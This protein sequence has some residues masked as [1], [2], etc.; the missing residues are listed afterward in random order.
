MGLKFS[1]KKS[2]EFASFSLIHS[3]LYGH[4]LEPLIM[5]AMGEMGKPARVAA[6]RYGSCVTFASGKEASAPGQVD[7]YT[8]KKWLDDYYD[9]KEN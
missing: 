2:H 6:G 7:V 4:T 3:F 9:G 1:R 8:M 5:I